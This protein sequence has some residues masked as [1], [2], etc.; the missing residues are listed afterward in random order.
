MLALCSRIGKGGGRDDIQGLWKSSHNDIVFQIP[1]EGDI[2]IVR[3][4]AGGGGQYLEVLE[5]VGLELSNFGAGGRGCQ[6]V[7]SVIKGGGSGSVHVQI[8]VMVH[9]TEQY[10]DSG[11]FHH[12][13]AL[14][15]T[16][17]QPRMDVDGTWRYTLCIWL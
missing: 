7:R 9:D 1:R 16:G 12:Q 17:K 15:M 5:D 8:R 2:I 4:L 3:Q 11:G 10:Q 6:D 14:Q 13:A